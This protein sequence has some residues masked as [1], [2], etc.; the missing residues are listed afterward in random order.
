MIPATNVAA[1][2]SIMKH[3]V[4]DYDVDPYS[5]YEV[6]VGKRTREAHFDAKRV[7]V[8]MMERLSWY[9]L[10]DL[11]GVE[12]L[13]S[14]LVPETI[15]GVR[16]Q[17][18]RERYEYARKVLHGEPVPASGWDPH[19]RERLRNTLLSHR[20]YSAEQALVRA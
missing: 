18:V 13:R 16:H 10:I 17:D 2:R 14:R 7:F 1:I 6:L 9:D 3:I 20:W 12:G 15:A 8:R 11:L 5:L 19:T 4:W